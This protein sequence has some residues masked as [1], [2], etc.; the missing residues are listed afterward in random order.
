MCEVVVVQEHKQNRRKTRMI[1]ITI[2]LVIISIITLLMNAQL[3]G[4]SIVRDSMANIEYY[5]IKAPINYVSN[6]FKEYNSLK[7]VYRENQR[8]KA[9]LDNYAREL[10]RNDTLENELKQM[11]DIKGSEVLKDFQVKYTT[12]IQRDVENWTSE[13]IIN[14]GS[15][16]A[17]KVGM[18]VLTSKGLIGIV[19]KTTPISSTVTLLTSENNASQL[20]VMI[21]S[22][23]KTY[24]GLLNNYS[25]KEKAFKIILLSTVDKIDIGSKCVTSG[26]GGRGKAPKGLLLGT[27]TG[28]TSGESVSGKVV[29]VKPSADF[30][31]IDYVALVKGN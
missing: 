17:V 25:V 1:F 19:S 13:V 28:L 3:P 18:P 31:N 11:K 8:L 7:N 15:S 22:G 30:D 4:S 27:V 2:L 23:N 9:S 20:P 14:M 21:Q 24:Y 26:L 16:S 12:V 6:V 10:A 5:V 29:T